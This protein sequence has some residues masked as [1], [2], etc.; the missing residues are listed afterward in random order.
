MLIYQRRQRRLMKFFFI[1]VVQ[2]Y[3]EVKWNLKIDNLSYFIPCCF[4]CCFFRTGTRCRIGM[5]S[6]LSIVYK[7]FNLSFASYLRFGSFALFQINV[8]QRFTR[9]CWKKDIMMCVKKLVKA[10]GAVM[11][12]SINLKCW[13]YSSKQKHNQGFIQCN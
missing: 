11:A 4:S 1:W 7:N 12:I 6:T 9:I 2:A 3:I 10:K 5:K 13:I 8:T